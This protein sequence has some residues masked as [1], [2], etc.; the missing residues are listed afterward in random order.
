MVTTTGS[1]LK[2]RSRE[3]TEGPERAPARSM[4]LAMGLTP[5]DLNKAVPLG[6]LT[7]PAT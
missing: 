3:I 7:L 1:R 4:L 2:H 6:S 5:D